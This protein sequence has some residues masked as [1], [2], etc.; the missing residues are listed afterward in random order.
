M[1]LVIRWI[2]LPWA[3]G[4]RIHPSICEFKR[5]ND[6]SKDFRKLRRSP[7]PVGEGSPRPQRRFRKSF[8]G[9]LN[10]P[11]EVLSLRI[12]YLISSPYLSDCVSLFIWLW[13]VMNLNWTAYASEFYPKWIR[14]G[15]H[16]NQKCKPH[17]KEMK[18]KNNYVN[19]ASPKLGTKV[20]SFTDDFFGK[21]SRML[22]ES[23]P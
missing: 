13:S 1:W 4:R 10:S 19:L 9:S 21:V 23:S 12:L 6:R 11:I 22:N 17:K 3:V 20:I 5:F 14:M 2:L 18:N 16:M 15:P 8:D 7:A